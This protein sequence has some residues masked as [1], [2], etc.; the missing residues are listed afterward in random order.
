[1]DIYYASVFVRKEDEKPK[2]IF[3]TVTASSTTHAHRKMMEHIWKGGF[4]I[5]YFLWIK[6]H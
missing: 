6:N 3:I 4:W 1:M 2:R 5:H